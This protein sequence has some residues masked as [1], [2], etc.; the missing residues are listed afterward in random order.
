MK[1]KEIV[2][3]PIEHA[4]KLLSNTINEGKNNTNKNTYPS[5]T[6]LICESNKTG[7]TYL[8]YS[9]QSS[10]IIRNKTSD[11]ILLCRHSQ[12]KCAVWLL[13]R[14]TVC[15][16]S[17]NNRGNEYT[18]RSAVAVVIMNVVAAVIRT[19]FRSFFF[20]SVRTIHKHFCY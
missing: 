5:I 16:S 15:S 3:T 10:Q 19:T 1:N 6:I 8:Q 20:S 4:A 14:G 18:G 2:E 11:F 13:L 12:K 17:S 7:G 9:K